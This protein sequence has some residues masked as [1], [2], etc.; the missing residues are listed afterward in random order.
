M[1]LIIVR[2]GQNARFS[3]GEFLRI[4]LGTRSLAKENVGT[5]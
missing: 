4:L 5:R 2:L 1:N 3:D